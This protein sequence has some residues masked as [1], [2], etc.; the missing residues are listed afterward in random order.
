MEDFQYLFH[1]EALTDNGYLMQVGVKPV[2]SEH[3]ERP[4]VD[5]SFDAVCWDYLDKMRLL[6]EAKG[7]KLV[8]IKAP[9]LSPVW[10]DPWEEQMEAYA[11][12]HDLLYINFLEHQEEI[13]LDWNTDTY[14]TGLHLNV[15]GAEKLSSYFGQILTEECDLTDHRSDGALSAFWQ[16]KCDT[17]H[18]RKAFLEAREGE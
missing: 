16:E 1:R 6:C 4:L 3:M 7:T 10:W 9:S 12:T 11:E 15:Y 18:E 14:D 2:T 8:L 5:Y 13:G 17:Y